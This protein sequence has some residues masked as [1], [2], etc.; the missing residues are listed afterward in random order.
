MQAS[1]YSS[2]P[3]I[4]LF[5][6]IYIQLQCSQ[7]LDNALS[8]A[9]EYEN[10]TYLYIDKICY[11]YIIGRM[12]ELSS[13]PNSGAIVLTDAQ[14]Q[15]LANMPAELEWFASIESVH[16]RRA[17]QSDIRSF[18]AFAG[19]LQAEDFRLVTR[20]HVLAWRRQLE[21]QLLS[22]ATVRRKLAALSS[23]YEFLCDRN[24]VSQNPVKGVKRPK[25]DTYEGKTPALGD[26]QARELLAL[27]DSE[28]LKGVRDR[29][30]LSVLLFHALRRE[31]LTKLRV[32]DFNHLRGGVPHLRVQG[33]G[34]KLRYV[35]THPASLGLVSAYLDK[36]GHSE[37][38]DSALFRPVR[39]NR[40]GSLADS[41]A[42]ALT[43]GGV[44]SSVVRKYLG[45]MGLN[46][47]LYGP[48][49]LRATA[50][51][52]ALSHEADIAKVQEWLGHANISTTRIYDRRQTKPEDSP[53][54]RVTY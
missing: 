1:G 32:K 26:H 39:N 20:A 19:M 6:A 29:A 9:N 52:N 41:L 54:F 36:S 47:E 22:G 50:A 43:P 7:G 44:Y 18:M 10:R 37:D 49:A 13:R 3:E 27:P 40:G 11:Q 2:T 4:S 48:H 24:A 46:E 5:I 15:G 17:Y 38:V 21:D 35:P 51:I 23:L 31:E 12:N 30:I 45:M 25:V 14:F 34:G 16:T 33:K 28:T 8:R 53:T 42:G